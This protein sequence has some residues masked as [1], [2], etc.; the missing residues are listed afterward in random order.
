MLRCGKK[1]PPAAEPEF[2]ARA[3]RWDQRPKNSHNRMITGIG[4]PISQSRIPRPMVV[5]LDF[6]PQV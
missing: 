6:N 2:A 1:A 4:T 3:N 5:S